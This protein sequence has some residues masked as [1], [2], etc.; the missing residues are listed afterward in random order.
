[1]TLL[2]PLVIGL[3][4]GP[5]DIQGELAACDSGGLVAHAF[6]TYDIYRNRG[7][8]VGLEYHHFSKPEKSDLYY[9]G[10]TGAFDY[11]GIY[12]KYSFD[13]VGQ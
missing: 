8:T 10:G 3:G 7:W 4:F 11:G 6:A 2:A 5:C 9:G 12:I 13:G 1:M